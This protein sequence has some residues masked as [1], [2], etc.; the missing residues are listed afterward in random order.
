MIFVASTAYVDNA[1]STK[2]EIE[3]MVL[4]KAGETGVNKDVSSM[5]LLLCEYSCNHDGIS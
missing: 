5:K 1:I 2:A 4:L 3:S